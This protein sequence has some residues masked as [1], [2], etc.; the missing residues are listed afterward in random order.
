MCIF[1]LALE[2]KI[3]STFENFW[4]MK[5]KI[6]FVFHIIILAFFAKIKFKEY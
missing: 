2:A 1:I 3:T 4:F 5:P 6:T